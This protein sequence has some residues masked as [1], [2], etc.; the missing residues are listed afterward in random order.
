[1]RDVERNWVEK[2]RKLKGV[3]RNTERGIHCVTPPTFGFTVNIPPSDV[4]LKGDVHYFI[5]Q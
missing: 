2:R 4:I 3:D 5:I 1:M